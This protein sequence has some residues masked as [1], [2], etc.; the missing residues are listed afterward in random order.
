MLDLSGPGGELEDI[1]SKRLLAK[2]WAQEVVAFLVMAYVEVVRR[3]IRWEVRHKDRVERVWAG[4]LPIIGCVWHGR[5]LMALAGWTQQHDR[6]VALASRSREGEIGSRFARW[7]KV[8]L[9]RGSSRNADKPGKSKGGEAAYRAMVRHLSAGGCGA[10]TPDGPRGPR[11]RAG[12][13]AVRMARD[14][15]VPIQPFTWSAARMTVLQR[16]WD[17]H[18][19]PHFFTRGI[20]IWGE[21]IHVPADASAEQLEAARQLLEDRLNAISRE[22][23]EAM[24]RDVIEPDERLRPGTGT[25]GDRL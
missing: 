14:T 6:M 3:T 5:V 1:M 18:C 24:G 17:R 25:A 7:Y 12:Y 11:M 2:P 4:R 13:G 19:L 16:S 15:G 23:D 21:P 10:L 8:G 9:V 20:I 22:A